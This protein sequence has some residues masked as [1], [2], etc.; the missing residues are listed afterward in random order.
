M[1]LILV[2][3][4]GSKSENKDNKW[5]GRGIELEKAVNDD[6]MSCSRW[7]FWNKDQL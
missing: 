7:I 6:R 5:Q 3:H 2:Y 1:W 4:D